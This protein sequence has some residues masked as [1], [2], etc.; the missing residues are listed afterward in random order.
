MQKETSTPTALILASASPRRRAFLEALRLP[1]VV[2]PADIDEEGLSRE[3]PWTLVARLSRTKAMAI[4]WNHPHAA[5]IGADTVVALDGTVFGKPSGPEDAADMLRRLRGRAH[6]VYSGVALYAPRQLGEHRGALDCEVA[7]VPTTAWA[8]EYAD[9]EIEA[10][11]ASGA[12]MDKAGAYG[13]QDTPFRPVARLRGCYAS[14]MGLPL[15]ALDALLRR[16]S[17]VPPVD[18]ATVCTVLTGVPCCRGE[19]VPME[20]DDLT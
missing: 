5:V 3:R 13:I 15:C 14:V 2:Q 9:A 18:V 8:R 20:L 10:Y 17:I 11:V 7:V 6:Q 19:D 1:F 12:P 4:S 16:A